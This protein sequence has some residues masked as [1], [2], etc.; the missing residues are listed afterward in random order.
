VIGASSKIAAFVGH[1][2]KTGDTFLT[3]MARAPSYT[4]QDHGLSFGAILLNLQYTKIYGLLLSSDCNISHIILTETTLLVIAPHLEHPFVPITSSETTQLHRKQ[5]LVGNLLKG[6]RSKEWS[7]L[8]SKA[9][10]PQ[11]ATT[12]ERA[13]IKSLWNHSYRLWIFCSNEDNKND[14][15]AVDEYKHK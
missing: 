11:L 12:C 8:R 1:I 9:I 5:A 13:M 14:N 4:E 10:V 15:R 6:H 7:K 2:M 3:V